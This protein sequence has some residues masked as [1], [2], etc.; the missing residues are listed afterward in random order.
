MDITGKLV[1]SSSCADIHNKQIDISFLDEGV[2]TVIITKGSWV[3]NLK[4]VKI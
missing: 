4:L 1:Y 2:Y 3:R